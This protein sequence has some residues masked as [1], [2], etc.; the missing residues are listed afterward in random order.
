LKTHSN[1]GVALI[2]PLVAYLDKIKVDR[3]EGLRAVRLVMKDG[4]ARGVLAIDKQGQWHIVSAGS[5][6]LASGGGGALYPATTNVQ[7][8][9]GEGYALAYEA[10]LCL[11]DMEFVQFV[12]VPR[13]APGAPRRRLPPLE[14]FLLNGATLRNANGEDLFEVSGSPAFTRDAITT[15]IEREIQRPRPEKGHVQLDLSRMSS[16]GLKGMSALADLDIQVQTAAHFFMGGIEVKD[17]L[18]TAMPGFFAAGEVMG[19]VHGANRLGGNALAET[20][21]FGALTGE[22]A[23]RFAAK[24]SN[25][26]AFEPGMTERAVAEVKESLG[27]GAAAAQ[28]PQE[29]E[30]ELKSIMA[31]CASPLRNMDT[32]KSG[33]GRLQ[34]LKDALQGLAPPS[35]PE[36]WFRTSLRHQITVG[37]MVLWSALKREES[38]GA[39]FREDFPQPDDRRWLANVVLWRDQT[40]SMKFIVKPVERK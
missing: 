28:Q 4:T 5:V 36:L 33:L 13:L 27:S 23:A 39:H 21:V 3:L 12:A 34:A 18:T 1:S 30:K 10:G 2:D 20:F 31:E 6:V 26:F 22:L 16:D 38:R 14:V 8:A 40:D 25:A 11:R 17:D 24:N 29:M 35:R 37:S 19:G 9:L 7:P 15:L 32:I